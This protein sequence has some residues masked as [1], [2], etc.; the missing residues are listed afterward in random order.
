MFDHPYDSYGPIDLLSLHVWAG[1]PEFE[2][3]YF[4]IRMVPT[5][6]WDKVRNQRFFARSIEGLK[7]EAEAREI[8]GITERLAYRRT[9]EQVGLVLPPLENDEREVE[10]T[11]AE[12][13]AYGKIVEDPVKALM[14]DAGNPSEETI[15]SLLALIQIE[16]EFSS[17]PSLLVRSISKTA[18]IAC[19]RAGGTHALSALS[20]GSKM[21]ALF[22]YLDDLLGADATTKAVVFTPFEQTLQ[23][24]RSLIHPVP[25]ESGGGDDDF[26][27]CAQT[28]H[29]H[30]LYFHGGLSD[31]QGDKVIEQFLT[32]P[33]SRILFST[34]AG[35]ES[36]NYQSVASVVIHYDAPLS[37]GVY[38]Q[39]LW[40]CRRRGQ[41]KRVIEVE[42]VLG[43]RRDLAARV[44]TNVRFVDARIKDLLAW[45]RDQRE[46]VT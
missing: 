13:D 29:G 15:K 38:D 30:D 27:E 12:L 11:S 21:E 35:S 33:G 34:D 46:A 24:I 41:T 10:L 16:R 8:H 37:L 7:G 32:D 3:R 42:F 28:I 43:P 1:L 20:P 36:Q 4:N 39:R 25:G 5:N 40:R 31:D 44:L 2:D 23:R 9:E 17:D 22:E 18:Q 26:Q 19:D 14:A 45:K 6:H